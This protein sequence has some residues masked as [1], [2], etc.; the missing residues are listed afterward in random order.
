M[1]SPFNR[2]LKRFQ[3]KLFGNK[4]VG[5]TTEYQAIYDTF[6]IKPSAAIASAQNTL[7]KSLVDSG[8]WVKL[9][10][11]YVLAGH[12]NANGESLINWFNP[13][14]FNATAVNAP[15]FVALEGFTG[16]GTTSYIDINWDILNDSINYSLNSASYGAY[17]RLNKTEDKCLIGATSGSNF[18]DLFPKLSSGN[19]VN[20]I[21]SGSE[22]IGNATSDPRGMWIGSRTASNSLKLYHNKTIVGTGSIISTN[23]INRNLHILARGGAV[24]STNQASMGFTASSLDQTDI[25]NLTDAFE[26]Y[27]DSNGKG[28]IP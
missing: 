26:V 12:T 1:A 22:S 23:L 28:V 27:M 21:N 24:F 19:A 25:N 6:I 3:P 4:G 9:D 16:D 11:F 14:T 17:A 10:T 18:N 2:N 8:V 15:A 13:G 5:F 7:V 20:R